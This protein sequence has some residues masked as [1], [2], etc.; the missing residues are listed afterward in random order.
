[1]TQT[2]GEPGTAYDVERKNRRLAILAANAMDEQRAEDI[3]V[4]D[5]RGLVDYADYFVIGS[6]SSLA[7]IKGVTRRVEQIMAKNGGKRLTE[8]DRDTGWVLADFG[9]ILVHV[10]DEQ[11]REFYQLE[12][13]WGDAPRVEWKI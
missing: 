12:D 10:F 6:A 1:M 11:A 4:L 3:V 13:L 7:R 8:P 9:D 2:A 5:M